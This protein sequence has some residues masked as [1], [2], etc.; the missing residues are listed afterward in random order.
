MP[1]TYGAKRLVVGAHYGVRDF[2]VQRL[3]G[4]YLG[5]YTI[6]L[7]LTVLFTSG[8]MTHDKWVGIFTPYWMKFLTFAAIVALIWHAWAGMANIWYDYAKPAGLR[9]V[10]HFLTAIWLLGCAGWA[11]QVLWRL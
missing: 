6:I 1:T 2:L 5:A 9:L 8:P 3:G 10:I 4:L 11:L 7:L